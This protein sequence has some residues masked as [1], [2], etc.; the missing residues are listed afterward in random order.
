M[1]HS[2]YGGFGEDYFSGSEAG[3]THPA[4]YANYRRDMLPFD[5]YSE[6]ICEIVSGEGIDLASTSVLV[7]GC[8]YGFTVEHLAGEMGVDAYGMDVSEY[9]IG[10]APPSI[11]GRLF[12]GD[13]TDPEDVKDV[14]DF[15][16]VVSEALLSCLT[17]REAVAA[18]ENMEHI[19]GELVIHNVWPHENE[20]YNIKT[21]EE[22]RTLINFDHFWFSSGDV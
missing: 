16:C 9:A 11:N 8:A 18:C 10:K 15:D 12:L 20:K 7:V 1:S 13:I 21:V 22:W 17:D 3:E 6:K 5:G 14:G 19:S 4:G 2:D